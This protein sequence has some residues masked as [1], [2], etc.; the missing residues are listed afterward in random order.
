MARS[1]TEQKERPPPTKLVVGASGVDLRHTGRGHLSVVCQL[2]LILGHAITNE[3]LTLNCDWTPA[4]G[5]D[6]RIWL[7]PS[8][9]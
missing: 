7:A 2:C 1:A 3:L 5:V 8:A 9:G 6:G 4:T